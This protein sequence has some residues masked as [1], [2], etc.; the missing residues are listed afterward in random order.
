M[1]VVVVGTVRRLLLWQLLMGVD[2]M[3]NSSCMNMLMTL[4]FHHYRCHDR[5][6]AR[7]TAGSAH[8][9]DDNHSC[10]HND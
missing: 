2:A 8:Y 7:T 3:S 9:E 5:D 10:H 4:C 6:W 1:I